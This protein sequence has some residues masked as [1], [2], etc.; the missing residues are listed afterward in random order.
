MYFAFVVGR[1]VLSP[2]VLQPRPRHQQLHHRE[3]GVRLELW[4]SICVPGKS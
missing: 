1:G 2:R 3:G 4:Q